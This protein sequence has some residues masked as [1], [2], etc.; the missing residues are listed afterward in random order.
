VQTQVLGRQSESREIRLTMAYLW[1]RDLL[2]IADHLPLWYESVRV[3]RLHCL[4]HVTMLSGGRSQS[5]SHVPA[6]MK[7]NRTIQEAGMDTALVVDES[8][9]AW[10]RLRE[11]AQAARRIA[12]VRAA[13]MRDRGPPREATQTWGFGKASPARALPEKRREGAE[14]K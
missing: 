14:W 10:P 7:A 4:V 8:D 5:T 12:P 13:S 11:A 6:V 3:S 2:T 1:S 9:G